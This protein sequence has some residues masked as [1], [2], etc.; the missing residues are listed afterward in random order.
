MVWLT[1]FYCGEPV[2][3]HGWGEI[4]HKECSGEK[5]SDEEY[6]KCIARNSKSGAV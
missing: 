1:C 3:M 6:K 5:L 2:N 4:K